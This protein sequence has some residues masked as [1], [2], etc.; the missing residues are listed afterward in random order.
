MKEADENEERSMEITSQFTGFNEINADEREQLGNDISMNFHIAV[1]STIP[2]E[3]SQAGTQGNTLENMN[4]NYEKNIFAYPNKGKIPEIKIKNDNYFES[5]ENITIKD[6]L[7]SIETYVD[8]QFEIC[9]KCGTRPN[10]YFCDD[11]ECKQNICE[12]CYQ[13]CHKKGHELIDLIKMKKETIECIKKI[14]K[15]FSEN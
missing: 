8:N 5:N 11:K 1:P 13:S 15:I 2:F 4:K 9:E 12:Y 6:Y 10:Y 14:N 7:N 3:S